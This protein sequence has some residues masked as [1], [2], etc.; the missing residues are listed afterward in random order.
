MTL[1]FWGAQRATGG[2]LVLL[3]TSLYQAVSLGA[4]TGVAAERLVAHVTQPVLWE[5]GVT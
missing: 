2:H 5:P 4:G 3:S 1:A